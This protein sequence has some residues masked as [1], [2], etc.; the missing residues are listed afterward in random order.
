MSAQI[1]FFVREDNGAYRAV[2]D[3]ELFEAARAKN[4]E[5]FLRHGTLSDPSATRQMLSIHFAGKKREEFVVIHL[6]SQHRV[7][8]IETASV[9]TID[10]ASVYPR[11]IVSSCLERNTAACIFAHNH[12][13]GVPEPSA[14]DRALTERLKQALALI[15]IRVLDHFVVG[16][17]TATSFAER[18]WL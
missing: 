10:A 4:R 2:T 12:P 16:A 8:D 14:A 3:A 6:D 1:P 17:E 18:G 5:S 7:L 11:S 15:D 9:G 13:S